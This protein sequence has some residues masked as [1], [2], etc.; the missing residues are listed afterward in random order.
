MK[1]KE[2]EEEREKEKH[3][4]NLSHT[5][6]LPVTTPPPPLAP[7]L[8]LNSHITTGRGNRKDVLFLFFWGVGGKKKERVG[9]KERK[10]QI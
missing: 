3:I 7:Y 1:L 5:N 8:C 2:E 10:R 4:F 6:R 9:R